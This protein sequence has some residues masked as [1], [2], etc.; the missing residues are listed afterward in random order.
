MTSTLFISQ[1]HETRE[2]RLCLRQKY[3]VQDI[4][5]KEPQR[6]VPFHACL[7]SLMSMDGS[8]LLALRFKT[9]SS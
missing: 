7:S 6:E 8:E 5:N 3:S 9:S 2:I 4:T 1:Q